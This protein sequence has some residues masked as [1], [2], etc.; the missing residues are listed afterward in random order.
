[1]TAPAKGPVL[2]GFCGI[3]RHQQ[4]RGLYAGHP[5][6]C[7]CHAPEP[8]PA[9]V[10]A[11][12]PTPTATTLPEPAMT[13][14]DLAARHLGCDLT[15]PDYQRQGVAHR[16]TGRLVDVW[17]LTAGRFSH[18]VLRDWAADPPLGP[19]VSPHGG[20][21]CRHDQLLEL[22]PIAEEESA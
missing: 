19:S 10:E 13:V 17:H 5:C 3:A 18:V 2:S 12:V 7:D 4:C 9:A 11:V 8:E 21:M 20:W 1:M 16:I 6:P 14:G 15:L 22:E